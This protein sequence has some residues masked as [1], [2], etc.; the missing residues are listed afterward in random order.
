MKS[1]AGYGVLLLPGLLVGL[2]VGIAIGEP[3]A[4][5]IGGLALGGLAAL[6]LRLRR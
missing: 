3:S 1:E 6:A 2:A 5:V 4:G